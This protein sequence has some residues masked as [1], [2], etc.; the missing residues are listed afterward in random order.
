[1]RNNFTYALTLLSGTFLLV[2]C[3][4]EK[5]GIV[6]FSQNIP[7]VLTATIQPTAVNLDLDTVNVVRL[8]NGDFQI[9]TSVSVRA[10]DPDGIQDVPTISFA[11]FK[12]GSV[13]PTLRGTFAQSSSSADTA[14]YSSMLTFAAKRSEAGLFTLEF[15]V[16]DNS[17]LL[18]N[19][20]RISMRINRNN[21]NPRTSNLAAPDT[22]RIPSGGTRLFLFAVSASDSDGIGDIA[23]VYFNSI[24]SS[25]PNNRFPLFD[26]GAITAHGDT[27]AG[28]GRFSGVFGIDSSNTSGIKE[29]RFW[30]RDNAGALSDSLRHFITVTP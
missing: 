13:D 20:I 16:S 28:D 24:N 30:A 6:D 17:R 15:Q 27:L 12:P 10:I 26:D 29:F 2:S 14:I 4:K 18:S 11:I 7:R 19:V 25:N 9:T 21:S 1:M 8:S 23:E 3:L 22:L 5:E